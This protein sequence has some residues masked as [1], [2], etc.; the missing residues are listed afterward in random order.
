MTRTEWVSELE[1]FPS[2]PSLRAHALLATAR[3][4]LTIG[5]RKEIGDTED[6]AKAN[7][8]CNVKIE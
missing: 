2:L 4:K 8:T 3:R 5:I 1:M 6:A 7:E